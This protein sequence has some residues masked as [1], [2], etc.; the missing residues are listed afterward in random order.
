[1][2]MLRNEVMAIPLLRSLDA[3]GLMVLGSWATTGE[4]GTIPAVINPMWDD[5]PVMKVSRHVAIMA[6][7]QGLIEVHAIYP[8]VTAYRIAQEGRVLLDEFMV[9]RKYLR[10][11]DDLPD[12]GENVA[13]MLRDHAP[14]PVEAKSSTGAAPAIAKVLRSNPGAPLTNDAIRAMV[15]ARYGAFVT[16]ARTRAIIGELRRAGMW[17]ETDS[18]G[19]RYLGENAKVREKAA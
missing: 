2:M 11:K 14:P 18:S 1:M 19:F 15:E 12:H 3:G 13:T 5:K 6:A 7:K 9:T 17:I 16:A 10:R 4:Y 8:R